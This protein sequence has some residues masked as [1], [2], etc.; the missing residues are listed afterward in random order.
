MLPTPFQ[1]A[2]ILTGP[3]GSG[4]TRL[5]IEW[6]E[7][8]GAE[9][10]SMDSMVLYRGMDIGTAKPTAE[11]R[12]RVSHHLI[13]VLD[14]WEGATVAWWLEQAAACC[15]DIRGR[16]K[17]VLFVGGTPLYVKTLLRGLFD[18]PAGDAVIRNRLTQEAESLGQNL[19]NLIQKLGPGYPFYPPLNR[20]ETGPSGR[21]TAP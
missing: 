19:E 7:R 14:P 8:L 18:G 9:I 6:A 10:V 5:A 13:D 16:G 11:E 2:M 1:E 15:R 12:A 21:S 4:K 20:L 17:R 3:T